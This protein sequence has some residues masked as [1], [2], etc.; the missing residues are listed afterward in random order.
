MHTIEKTD[1]QT[2]IPKRISDSHKGTYGHVVSVCGSYGMAGAAFFAA[3]AALRS[4]AGLCTAVLPDSI[5]PIVTKMLPEAVFCPLKDNLDPLKKSCEKAD[6]ILLGCGLGLSDEASRKCD[7]VLECRQNTPMVLDADGLNW[8][9][10]LNT[11]PDSLNTGVISCILTPHPTEAA[12]LLH[13]T[14]K[15][16][17]SDRQAAA[18]KIAKQ[19]H[20]VV[21]LKGHHTLI[22]CPGEET[23]LNPTGCSGMATGGSGD[24]LAGMITSFLAQGCS[25]YDA[26]KI[27]VY[28]HGIAGE[29][30]SNQLSEHGMLPS[31]MLPLIA[32]ILADYE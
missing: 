27:G 32:K 16:I 31:D 22:A 15:E 29:Q 14:T 3:C 23:L 18:E 2:C 20:A 5:Y 10:S 9:A 6:A 8:L 24:V 19:Y 26:A 25:P 30:A 4:G 28:L 11:I 12:R 17:Q 21:V 13:C 1:I 7:A